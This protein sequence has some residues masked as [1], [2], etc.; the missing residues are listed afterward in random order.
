MDT[1][2]EHQLKKIREQISSKT[3]H[4]QQHAATLL[5]VEETIKEQ[6]VEVE[7]SSY[8]AALLTLLEQQAGS[9]S[10]GLSNAIIYLLSIILPYVSTQVLRAKFSTM[11]AVL[12]QSL[13]LGS[14]D[15]ALLRSIVASLEAVLQSQ[16]VGSWNQPVSQGT[17]KSLLALSVD[18]KPK[19]RKRA[20]E[21]VS[22]LLSQPPLPAPVHPAAPLAVRFVLDMLGN[23]KADTQ[24]AIYTL[25]LVKS[26]NMTWP[27][28]EFKELCGSLMQLPKLNT[29]F[30]TTLSFQALETVFSSAAASL[31]EEQ[32][33]DLL[34]EIIDLKPNVNDLLSSEAWLKIV[35]NGYVA[36]ASITPEMCFESLPDLIDLVLPDIELG[37]QS[38][39]ESATQCIWAMIRDCIPTSKLGSEGISHIVKTLT[40]GLSYRYRESWALM[41]LLIA[42]L[43]Q[44]L[45]SFAHPVMDALM[46]EIA[47]MRMEPEFQFK[48][49]ADAVLGAAV[50]AVGPKIFLRILPLNIDATNRQNGVG[51]AWLLPLMKNHIRNAPLGYFTST[52]L[53]LADSL[54]AQS[55]RFTSQGREI[56]AKVYV[57]LCHQ[58]WALLSGFCNVPSDIIDAF[59]PAFAARLGKEI[60]E[61]TML[62]SSVCAALS[63]LLTAVH[64]LSHN[65]V[66]NS[67]LTKQQALAAEEHL[68]QF[69]QDFLTQLFNVFAQSP[70][71][72][73]GY[74]M[75]TITA[76]LAVISESE[77][78]ATFVKVCTMLDGVLKTH[79]PPAAAE[80]T[81]KYLEAHPPPHAYTMMD[82]ATTMAPYLDSDRAQM[83]ARAAFLLARQNDD[84]TLQ[85]KGYKAIVRLTEQPA[86][87]PA[88]Q[89]IESSIST[90]LIPM[91]LES[92]ETVA[93]SSRRDR[94]ALISRLSRQL[95][96]SQIHFIPAMLSE[97]ILGTK[98]PNERAR[99][100]AFD[101]LL[102]M[103]K[104]MAQGGAIDMAALSGDA[105]NIESAEQ[106]EHHAS[107]Y[108]YFK[109][110]S[111]GLAAQ[112]PHMIS[113][114]IASISRALFEF[115]EQLDTEFIIELMGTVLMFVVNNNREIAKS[116]L[117]FVKVI[118]VVLP[119][120][121]LEP[122]L[123]EIVP[124]IL[125]WSHEYKNQLRLKCRHILD[126]LARRLGL[127]VVAKAVPE[128]H[129]KIVANMRKR[130]QRAKRTRGGGDTSASAQERG[131]SEEVGA[132]SSAVGKNS[133]GNAY[134]DV[135]YGSESE[136]DDSD[137]EGAG[138]VAGNGRKGKKPKKQQQQS[139]KEGSN[140]KAAWIKEDTDGPLDFLDR[141]AFTHFATANPA[142][143]PRRAISMPKMKNGKLLFEDPEEEARKAKS[144]AA[145]ST[146]GENG[147]DSTEATEDYYLESIKSK[148][149]FYRTPGQKIKFRKRKAGDS[150]DDVEMGSD[151]ENGRKSG[152]GLVKRGKDSNG[153]A[154][155]RE[156]KAKKGKGDVK[157]GNVDPF[158][159]IPLNP[160]SMKKGLASIKG[161]NKKEKRGHRNA[162]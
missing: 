51:R 149:G 75:D 137:D 67:P 24:S 116:S 6:S 52:L 135:I 9:G 34:V 138:G 118:A 20:Q 57:A 44:R 96:D 87:S 49:E 14:A 62:R 111:A 1:G 65:D 54:A 61:D 72:S 108:E 123:T 16:D 156:F 19:I 140:R 110:I 79:K 121:L 59:T 77:V 3:A 4:Q 91:L 58:I 33:R 39:K 144:V 82:L 27:P 97:V 78:N 152:A 92:A 74:I 71:A 83:L 131:L 126:R 105:G 113:A 29:P 88:H 95:P 143:K 7:P 142:E 146:G 104:R 114:T 89:L 98:E 21:A 115:Y 70:G 5:A 141:S 18:S 158:A 25:Q 41:F 81:E 136:L 40:S 120:E 53:P 157:R 103:G 68:A 30:L 117:G 13:D 23:A 153:V 134:E 124:A 73:R 94:L 12:S 47:N 37:K 93:L 130:Q 159:Y 50:R 129:A 66:T 162:V 150:D 127:D 128:E 15:V 35:Q 161:S 155:G 60:E 139:N 28:E 122:R 80:L 145:A 100:I 106:A 45:G 160:K 64:H 56:E 63:T 84:A 32:F 17:F 11:M 109:I 107:I 69:A 55:L 133:Y 99:T 151:G 26:T 46:V 85:K 112:T 101:T 2:L 8:F 154:Y 36:Y 132:A 76:F 86:G 42:A 43:F 147:A 119:K 48:N 90:E 31:E 125:K 148:D 102:V 38:T 10:K 22:A